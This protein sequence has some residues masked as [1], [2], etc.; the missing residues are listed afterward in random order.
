M[1]GA[2][3]LKVIYEDTLDEADVLITIGDSLRAQDW[4]EGEYPDDVK[5]QDTRGGLYAVFLAAKR[6]KLPHTDGEWMDWMDRV[7]IPEDEA[8]TTEDEHLEP[9]ESQEPS[10]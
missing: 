9:G 3:L 4:A 5:K 2:K 1:A 7:T 8:D 6:A 10:S